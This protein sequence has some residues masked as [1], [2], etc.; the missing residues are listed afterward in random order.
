MHK[1]VAIIL[2]CFCSFGL[3]NDG[4]AQRRPGR[5]RRNPIKLATAITYG[6]YINTLDT[7]L[8][9][10]C[11]EAGSN[12][13]DRS[14]NGNDGTLV[15]DATQGTETSAYTRL[16]KAC[17]FDGTLDGI[18]VDGT[19]SPTPTT[20]DEDWSLTTWI[21]FDSLANFNAFFG[22][23]DSWSNGHFNCDGRSGNAVL[24]DHY[25]GGDVTASAAVGT[26]FFFAITYDRDGLMTLYLDGAS[27]HTQ[28][29]GGDTNWPADQVTWG[30]WD[31]APSRYLNGTMDEMTLHSR[32]LTAAEISALWLLGSTGAQP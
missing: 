17:E 14:G 26:W 10:N 27:K 1:F 16:G 5:A 28:A 13:T 31:T 29:A 18:D 4:E 15:D 20:D 30:K 2:A 6:T 3:L 12:I 23:Q 24:C 11:S 8:Y 32:T 21:N 9:Y 19:M 7:V 22:T 25:N